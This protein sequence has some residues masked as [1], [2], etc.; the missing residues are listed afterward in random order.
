MLHKL[1]FY[2]VNLDD[3]NSSFKCIHANIHDCVW[4]STIILFLSICLWGGMWVSVQVTAELR[5]IICPVG[6]VT[7]NLLH[8][9]W[10]LRN[11]LG[12][13]IRQLCNVKH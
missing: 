1:D 9:E 8:P 11:K 12:F 5:G 3:E 7:G 6:R 4:F 2:T 13:S 10:V